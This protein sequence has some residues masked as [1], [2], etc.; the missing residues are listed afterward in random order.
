MLLRL[1]K[2]STPLWEFHVDIS[3]ILFIIIEILLSTP[4][5]EFQ[6]MG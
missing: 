3:D 2:L 5:W 1:K 4:L 6:G